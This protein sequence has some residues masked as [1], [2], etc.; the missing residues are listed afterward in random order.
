MTNRRDTNY[1]WKKSEQEMH[2]KP[3]EI[4]PTPSCPVEMMPLRVIAGIADGLREFRPEG[5]AEFGLDRIVIS[6]KGPDLCGNPRVVNDSPHE[7]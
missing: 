6:Q 7:L 3:F 4:A 2:G 1:S 5:I